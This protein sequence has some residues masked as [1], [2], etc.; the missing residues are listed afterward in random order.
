MHMKRTMMIIIEMVACCVVCI[1]LIGCGRTYS[2]KYGKSVEQTA[3]DPYRFP[4]IV[5]ETTRTF[6]GGRT[7]EE[8]PDLVRDVLKKEFSFDID[9]IFE[10]DPAEKFFPRHVSA[11]DTVII[12]IEIDHSGLRKIG[13]YSVGTGYRTTL[14]RVADTDS[15]GLSGGLSLEKHDYTEKYREILK[16]DGMFLSNKRLDEMILIC[17]IS[18]GRATGIE[19]A[20][21]YR[22]SVHEIKLNSF[23][24]NED[25]GRIS[26]VSLAGDTEYNRAFKS[27]EDFTTHVMRNSHVY[28]HPVP[29][30]AIDSLVAKEF[31]GI[32]YFKVY[33]RDKGINSL[34]DYVMQNDTIAFYTHYEGSYN[35]RG[36]FFDWCRCIGK[37]KLVKL[38]DNV[39][40][41]EDYEPGKD[42]EE[43]RQHIGGNSRCGISEINEGLDYEV[44][45]IFYV[46]EGHIYKMELTDSMTEGARK[47]YKYLVDK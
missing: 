2:E 33:G 4:F 12:D 28:Q 11:E 14:Y 16:S 29:V 17:A 1:A 42:P 18:E 35:R 37:G 32:G 5:Q 24:G 15:M 43:F 27:R 30:E 34:K 9:S 19:A 20:R 6:E 26:I 31:E 22:E 13:S 39:C 40:G 3:P 41:I 38:Y 44:L 8:L 47:Y 25:A 36:Y 21:R 7:P 23:S 45:V 46:K 10:T